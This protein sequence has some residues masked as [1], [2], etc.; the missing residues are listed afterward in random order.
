[1]AIVGRKTL[2]AVKK[3]ALL[4][5]VNTSPREQLSLFLETFEVKGEGVIKGD[6]FSSQP[7]ISPPPPPSS[8]DRTAFKIMA[9]LVLVLNERRK[10]TAGDGKKEKKK[11][12]KEMK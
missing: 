8:R 7:P 6:D 9:L 10:E 2:A 3:R 4:L 11:K 1:M 12:E 5:F